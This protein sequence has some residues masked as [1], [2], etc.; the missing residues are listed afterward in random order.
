MYTEQDAEAWLLANGLPF[1]KTGS[2]AICN[3]PVMDT[4]ADFVVLDQ[5]GILNLRNWAEATT[6]SEYEGGTRTF[7]LGEVN[8]I[9]VEW[10]EDF[11]RWKIATQIATRLNLTSKP[12]RIALFQGVLYDNWSMF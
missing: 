1:F 9:V 8:L 5:T 6:D 2:R 3:P 4:D 10:E 7:R 11:N 12:E